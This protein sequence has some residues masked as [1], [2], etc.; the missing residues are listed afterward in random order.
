MTNQDIEAIAQIIRE[1]KTSVQGK[2]TS[3]I[4]V[5]LLTKHL[6]D[7][8]SQN[9]NSLGIVWVEVAGHGQGCYCNAHYPSGRHFDRDDF[10][11]ACYGDERGQVDTE[12]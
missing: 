11:R 2:S 1:H 10:I 12:E 3:Y 4:S 7:Y 5:V 6:A 8:M 9:T